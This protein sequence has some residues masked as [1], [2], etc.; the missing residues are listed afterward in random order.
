MNKTIL[1]IAFAMLLNTIAFSQVTFKPG[2]R[3]GLN[4]ASISNIDDDSKAAFYAGIFGELKLGDKYALQPE[5]TYSQQGSKD[6]DLDYLAVRITNKFYF[7]NE[8]LPI[9]ILISPGFDFNLHGDT[10]SYS[11]SYGA[12][13]NFEADLSFSGG[14]G[15]DFPFG[16][17]VEA[18]YKQG[19]IDVLDSSDPV[20]RLNSLFQIG[21]LY[22][23]SF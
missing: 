5:I 4:Y 16:L 13:V 22:K 14:I 7:F 8:D 17:G 11:N 2:V 21:A 3:A 19:I 1:T 20:S 6:I 23:F 18:R 15:Y 10:H 9:F 12:G